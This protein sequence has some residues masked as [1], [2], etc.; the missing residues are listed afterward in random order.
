MNAF[1][2]LAFGALIGAASSQL[3][4]LTWNTDGAL[5]DGVV[6][7]L[8]QADVLAIQEAGTLQPQLYPV[9]TPT[10]RPFDSI[11]RENGNIVVVDV[12]LSTGEISETEYAAGVTEYRVSVGGQTFFMYYYDRILD[13]GARPSPV[14]DTR[15]QNMA[16]IS[17]TRAQ[18]VYVFA[19]HSRDLYRVDVNRPI[20]G[21]RLPG[22][23]V[24][25]AH[26]DPQRAS[27]EINDT[28]AIISAFVANEC[29]LTKWILMGDFN[30]EPTQIAVPQAPRNCYQEVVFPAQPTKPKT[31]RVID[32]GICGGPLS[33]HTPV[34]AVTQTQRFRSDHFPVIIQP[35][36][37]RRQG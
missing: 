14:V 33:W 24:F 8:P 6:S 37:N 25:S 26:T 20:L 7:Y 12:D 32:F 18:T 30:A 1:F 17:R 19:P 15:K 35:A 31:R 5:W 13:P 11:Q 28:I 23:L 21:I 16:I 9:R 4:F 10:P 34:Q 3:R 2:L 22:Y 27:N 36:A 29:H